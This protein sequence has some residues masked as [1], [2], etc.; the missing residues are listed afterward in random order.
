MFRPQLDT[1]LRSPV[2]VHQLRLWFAKMLHRST[3]LIETYYHSRITL[4]LAVM[5]TNGRGNIPP[6]PVPKP[7]VAT[8]QDQFIDAPTGAHL[9][10]TPVDLCML[11]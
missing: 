7:A 3:Y 1:V 5:G 4:L 11:Q 8:E 10:I 9:Y 6:V 2:A